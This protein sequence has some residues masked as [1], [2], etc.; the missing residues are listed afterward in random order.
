MIRSLGSGG[1]IRIAGLVAFLFVG[2]TAEGQVVP[3]HVDGGGPA[4]EGVSLFG[5]LSPHTATGNGTHLGKYSGDQ[6]KF[7]SLSFDPDTFSGTFQGSFVFVAA[8]GDEL[9]CTYGDVDNGADGPGEYQ[10]IDVGGGD[11]I[12]VFL[13]EF[14]PLPSKCTGRFE[15][16]I[17]GSFTMLAVTEPFPLV[18]D[19]F[20]YSP[21]FNYSWEGKGWLEFD[22]GR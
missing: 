19:E 13:R 4:P 21:P 6:G 18:L 17:D 20:G 22:R 7:Y 1:A 11:V 15:N 5:D 10:V 16:L 2:A 9:F 12:V 3:F 8:N 14:N